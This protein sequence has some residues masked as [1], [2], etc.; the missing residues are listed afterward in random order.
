[1]AGHKRFTVAWAAAGFVDTSLSFSSF[2][3]FLELYR[4]DVR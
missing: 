4:T 2:S 3:S 1:M